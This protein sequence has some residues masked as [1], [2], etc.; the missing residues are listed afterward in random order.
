MFLPVFVSLFLF[1]ASATNDDATLSSGVSATD[2]GPIR[3]N[4]SLLLQLVNEKRKQ[5]CQC[6]DTYYYP[7]PELAWNTQLESAA[8]GHSANMYSNNFF[9]HIAPDGTKGGAR[10][11]RAGYDWRAYGENIA[12]GYTSEKEVIAGWIKSPTHCKNL[13]NR[14]YKEMGVGRVGKFWTQEF[15]MR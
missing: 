8:L 10:I 13:M 9:S 14:L 5:G 6:G 11:E 12:S 7:V 3:V 1:A 4:R 2:P 15:G